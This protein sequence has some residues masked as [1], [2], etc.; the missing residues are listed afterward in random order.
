VIGS[1]IGPAF[2]ALVQSMTGG[3]RAALW[4]SM[5]FPAVGLLLAIAG[6]RHNRH[7]GAS[8]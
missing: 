5:I 2:F 8:H 4:L 3:Y 1:A 6:L 7:I